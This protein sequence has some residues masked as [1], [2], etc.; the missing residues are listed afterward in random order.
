MAVFLDVTYA[1]GNEESIRIKPRAIVEAE[2]RYGG[3]LPAIEGTCYAAW[4]TKGRP[5]GDFD[6]WLDGLDEASDR[7]EK[8]GPLAQAPSPEG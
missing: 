8:T 5:G 4:V 6:A 1:D 3:G 2:R 7:K